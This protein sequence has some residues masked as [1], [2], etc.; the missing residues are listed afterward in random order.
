M[1]D[2]RERNRLLLEAQELPWSARELV[3]SNGHAAS[4]EPA[5]QGQSRMIRV[6]QRG[7]EVCWTFS[8]D[9]GQAPPGF[10]PDDVPFLGDLDVRFMWDRDSGLLVM[11]SVPDDDEPIRRL[12]ERLVALDPTKLPREVTGLAEGLRAAP[13]EERKKLLAELDL[14]EGSP[15]RTWIQ[16]VFDEPLGYM[17][18]STD[19]SVQEILTFHEREGWFVVDQGPGVGP[20]RRVEMHRSGVLRQLH[21]ASFLGIT[22]INLVE[23]P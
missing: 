8:L 9:A 18:E 7:V 13:P 1:T 17:P 5:P 2:R 23:R 10:Y 19:A 21:A 6:T 4:L 3:G 11:W 12:R 14:A 22:M 15:L 20:S 16:S